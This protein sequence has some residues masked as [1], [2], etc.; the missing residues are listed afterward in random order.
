MS[1]LLTVSKTAL[2]L[3]EHH[4]ADITYLPP[5]P[6][7]EEL[8]E[9]IAEEEQRRAQA[10][11]VTPSNPNDGNTAYFVTVDWC[12]KG[13]RGIFCT[14]DGR[15]FRKDGSPHTEA[16]MIDILG[17]FWIILAPKSEL[18]T[19]EEVAQHTY[20]RALAE[21]KNQYGIGCREADVPEHYIAPEQE[22]V[23]P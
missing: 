15:C 19:E 21:Y 10:D 23:G 2:H 12:K 17:P 7:I 18:F 22:E 13:L 3:L 1:D 8:R 20:F 14:T 6:I 9:A 16:E 4:E 5:L 11:D